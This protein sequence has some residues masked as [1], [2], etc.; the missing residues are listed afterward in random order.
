MLAGRWVR[1]DFDAMCLVACG[2]L[3]EK[4]RD[5]R[6]RP[7]EDQSDSTISGG[8]R[9]VDHTYSTLT[10]YRRGLSADPGRLRYGFNPSSSRLKRLGTPGRIH[11]LCSI[12]TIGFMIRCISLQFIID[13]THEITHNP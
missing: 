4:R 8:L 1:A 3:S 2:E 5:H 13:E 6:F 7:A 11:N 12:L 9:R 10:R